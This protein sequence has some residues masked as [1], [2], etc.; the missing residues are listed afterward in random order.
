M[1]KQVALVTGASRG[2]GAATARRLARDG[3]AVAIN[4]RPEERMVALAEQ[5]AAEIR[6]EGG[7]A[8]VYAADVSEA[9]AVDAMV[10]RCEAELGRVGVL[11][12]NAMVTRRAP[13]NEITVD[14][15]DRIM[16]VNLRGAFLCSRRAF[17]DPIEGGAIVTV[18]SV[19]ARVG[20]AD[21][22]PYATTKAGLLGFTRS[23]ARALGPAG[24]RVNAVMP[25]AIRTEEEIETT[26]DPEE[27]ERN[28]F[29]VQ[30]LRRRGVA[31]DIAGVVSF[32]AGPDSSFMSGQTV[33]VDGGWVL[34]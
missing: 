33:C 14:D 27:A 10:G 8:A 9:G 29:A 11:V 21:S 25:G 15:W 19:L 3:M 32:L 28:A 13:W 23:M 31:E 34:S 6:D 12:N 20:K 7:T 26:P 5:V 1:A 22:V 16:G 24:V 30:S 17:A 4:S 18:S 2:I